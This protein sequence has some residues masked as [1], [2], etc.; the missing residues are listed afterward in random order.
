VPQQAKRG[1]GTAS[2][3]TLCL[4]TALAYWPS[5]DIKRT[6]L[7]LGYLHPLKTNI[8]NNCC[9]CFC[10]ACRLCHDAYNPQG[11]QPKREAGPPGQD[12]GHPHSSKELAVMRQY[13]ALNTE[14]CP[15]PGATGQDCGH[16]HCNES[17]SSGCMLEVQFVMWWRWGA[18]QW[19]AWPSLNECLSRH[20]LHA[21]TMYVQQRTG[22]CWVRHPV[23]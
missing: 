4:S 18:G 9:M 11:Q 19:V 6:R 12:C 2:N 21:G 15:G 14:H 8:T 5:Q 7:W 22:S 16:F 10:C 3:T 17:A 13:A 1:A 23:L 20:A